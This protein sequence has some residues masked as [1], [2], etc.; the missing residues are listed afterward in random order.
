MDKVKALI[1]QKPTVFLLVTGAYLLSVVLWKWLLH[2]SFDAVWFVI[3]GGIG[4]YFLDAAEQ[5]FALNPSPFRSVVF[6]ALFAVVAFFVVTSST[7]VMGSGLVL[8]LFLQMI[9]WQVGEWKLTGNLHSWYRMVA[10]TLD[11]RTERVILVVSVIIFLVETY[12]F[13]S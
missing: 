11:A 12:I 6:Q 5:F 9:L 7:S 1:R 13:I 3:G 10:G 8:S 4:I 2:P